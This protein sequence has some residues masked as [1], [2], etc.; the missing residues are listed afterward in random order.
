MAKIKSFKQVND[1]DFRYFSYELPRY[2]EVHIYSDSEPY[3]LFRYKKKNVTSH[4]E[5]LRLA[6][7]DLF[8]A[9]DSSVL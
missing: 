2:F 4:D 8:A 5:A 3:S 6:R 1:G 7:L 9:H